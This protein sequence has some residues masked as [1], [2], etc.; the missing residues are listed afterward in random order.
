M[1]R[2]SGFAARVLSAA[3]GVTF[4]V[5]LASGAAAAAQARAFE[6]ESAL[7]DELRAA[8]S[9][10][11]LERIEQLAA[12]DADLFPGV[13]EQLALAV[14][15]QDERAALQARVRGAAAADRSGL[16]ARHAQRWSTRLAAPVDDELA[17]QDALAWSTPAEEPAVAI[18][19]HTALAAS[20]ES[21]GW[22]A[23]AAEHACA[24][25]D[26]LDLDRRPA[27][28][29]CLARERLAWI[30]GLGLPLEEAQVRERLGHALQVLHQ[31]EESHRQLDQVIETALRRS[32]SRLA[33]RALH[34]AT[35][36]AQATRGPQVGL[37]FAELAEA[38]AVRRGDED[39]AARA[40]R[41]QAAMLVVLQ[42]E[43]RAR[44]RSERSIE[45]AHR[46][47]LPE[48]EADCLVY[49]AQLELRFG[50]AE[51]AVEAL[52][53]AAAT[54]T[55]PPPRSERDRSVLYRSARLR[56]LVEQ[57]R[58]ELSAHVLPLSA[59]RV[60]QIEGALEGPFDLYDHGLLLL[61]LA[62]H[63]ARSGA[64]ARAAELAHQVIR[65]ARRLDHDEFEA[66]GLVRLADCSA[67]SGDESEALRRLRQALAL[68]DS[69][70][71]PQVELSVE[72]SFERSRTASSDSSFGAL[73]AA[74]GF[75]RTGS[76]RFAEE[77]LALIDY[78]R[79]RTLAA[80][81][82]PQAAAA[83]LE[84][85]DLRRRLEQLAPPST[86]V[87]AFDTRAAVAVA[88]R[89]GVAR[90]FRL[91]PADRLAHLVDFFEHAAWRDPDIAPFAQAAGALS[92]ALLAPVQSELEHAS[93]LLIVADGPLHR[94]PFDLLLDPRPASSPRSFADAAFLFRA[95]E[96]VHVPRLGRGDA[97][98]GRPSAPASK[99]LV[100]FGYGGPPSSPRAPLAEREVETIAALFK[101]E[102]RFVRVGDEASEATFKRV[103]LGPGDVLHIAAHGSSASEGLRSSGLALASGEGEDGDVTLQELCARPAPVDLVLLSACNGFVGREVDA[104]GVLSSAWAFLYSGARAA[105]VASA[106][107]DDRLGE[108]MFVR[109]HRRLL[110]GASPA[111]A[112]ALARR[113]LLGSADALDIAAARLPFLLQQRLP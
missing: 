102:R 47:G 80:R 1:L 108:R 103:E 113:E 46:R 99:R 22:I 16:L 10:G 82:L 19:I 71:R 86:L 73:I 34:I 93:E 54:L 53:R 76:P 64:T 32:D 9:H 17:R 37:E 104:E 44:E 106:P 59:A 79:A 2:S 90:L 29:L 18:G 89:A 50:R 52:E 27:D 92:K 98:A 83:V 51:A 57:A 109:V 30:E 75:E 110:E 70:R 25:L 112:L 60:E 78:G 43:Q 72:G 56:C 28:M 45:F 23:L 36:T 3:L 69:S 84:V 105:I 111:R 100:A 85:S 74:Q 66:R 61:A 26:L 8:L 39:A 35:W 58:L 5:A 65:E 55:D 11:P 77:A 24:V 96:V 101:P 107:I 88:W 13:V 15:A 40:L 31:A 33:L 41:T 63:H 67:R 7:V 14:H 6:R 95:L 97:D 4:A 12:S 49:R 62:E 38:L 91:P 94:V 68:R 48:R 20:L 81:R 42:D 87:L 21:A